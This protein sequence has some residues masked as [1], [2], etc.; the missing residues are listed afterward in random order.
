[1][2]I[3]SE[4]AGKAGRLDDALLGYHALRVI[5]GESGV[6]PLVLFLWW[7]EED[8]ASAEAVLWQALD[9][10]PSSEWSHAWLR[11]LGDL[12]RAQQRW[13]EAE[14]I[15]QKTLM[16][17][18]EDLLAHIGLGWLYYERG[19][20]LQ[21][22]LAEFHQATALAPDRSEGYSAMGEV[23]KREN[24]FDEAVPWFGRALELNPDCHW[25]YAHWADI[26]LE[27]GDLPLAQELYR[28]ALSRFPDFPYA[29]FQIARAYQLEDQPQFAV[30]AIEQAMALTKNPKPWMLLRAAEVCEWAGDYENAG[31]ICKNVPAESLNN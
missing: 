8:L 31:S 5:T 13:E 1:L 19:A 28:E 16:E 21:A 29:Y 20:G 4:Q 10:Y 7:T 15:Y 14:R 26:A 18:S 12:M 23:L 3:A 30:E 6:F 27:I 22:A 24:R 9:E 17:D 2:R 25:C 11:N